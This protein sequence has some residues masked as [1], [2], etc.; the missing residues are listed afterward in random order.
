MHDYWKLNGKFTKTDMDFT[1]SNAGQ[2]SG[3]GEKVL[4]Y[5]NKKLIGTTKNMEYEE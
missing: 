1:L 4:L 5:N 3:R 2:T